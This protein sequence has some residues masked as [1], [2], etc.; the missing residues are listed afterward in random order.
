MTKNPPYKKS[1]YVAVD[2]FLAVRLNG[3]RHEYV[4]DKL[5]NQWWHRFQELKVVPGRF[6]WA[7]DYRG[8][9]TRTPIQAYCWT[10][11]ARVNEPEEDIKSLAKVKKSSSY[12]GEDRKIKT[13]YRLI[14]SSEDYGPYTAEYHKEHC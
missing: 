2:E 6:K 9:K 10:N 3:M 11:W 13:G 1:P 7:E 14:P 12:Q 8:R 4:Y 5:H